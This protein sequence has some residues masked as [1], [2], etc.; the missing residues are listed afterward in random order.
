MEGLLKKYEGN[1]DYVI[2]YGYYQEFPKY[3]FKKPFIDEWTLLV[4][5]AN[6]QEEL[7]NAMKPVKYARTE[8]PAD[9][10]LY[11]DLDS[12]YITFDRGRKVPRKPNLDQLDDNRN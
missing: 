12:P 2:I 5:S 7:K 4:E 11:A 9:R 3:A 8:L 1:S 10:K 6:Q